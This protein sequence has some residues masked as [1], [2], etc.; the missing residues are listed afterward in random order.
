MNAISLLYYNIESSTCSGN[1]EQSPSGTT[2]TGFPGK[3]HYVL[4]KLSTSE[5]NICKQLLNE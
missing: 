4:L 1:W 3:L 5:G 2:E